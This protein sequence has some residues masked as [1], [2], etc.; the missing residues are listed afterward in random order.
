MKK[1][2]VKLSNFKNYI[3]LFDG[4]FGLTDKEKEVL[5]GF[6]KMKI[7]LDN[8]D[9]DEN[10]FNADRKKQVAKM[11]GRDN[12]NTLNN[13]IMRLKNKQAISKVEEGYEISPVLMPQGEK[14]IVFNLIRDE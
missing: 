14:K 4:I 9:I 6:I 12:F 8:K 1:I 3:S 5:V 11:L 10:P 2:P 7:F 13:Y